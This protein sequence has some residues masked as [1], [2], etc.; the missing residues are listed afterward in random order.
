[1]KQS[2]KYA[3]TGG[4]G[5]GKSDFL[6]ILRKNGYPAFS[7]DEISDALWR[8]RSYLDGLAALF[9]ECVREGTPDKAAV[10]ARVFSDSAALEALNGYA[11]PRIMERLLAEMEGFPLSFAE[12][13]LLY[14]R[15]Y[16]SLFDGVIAL[17]RTEGERAK[18]VARRDGMRMD[19]VKRRMARQLDPSA[20]DMRGCI[21]IENDGTLADLER[22]AKEVLSALL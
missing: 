5:S 8:E 21:V 14:E 20:L 1:M 10:A 22:K 6:A 2:K 12:V 17:R 18:S 15:G 13:P 3:I 9:P 4:I 19:D 7:C 16:Q 11:H